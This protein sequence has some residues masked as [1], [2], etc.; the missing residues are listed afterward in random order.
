MANSKPR[1]RKDSPS[2]TPSAAPPDPDNN[3]GRGAP[4]DRDER[5]RQKSHEASRRERS[6]TQQSESHAHGAASDLDREDAD[7]QRAGAARERP[8]RRA[9]KPVRRV[10][11]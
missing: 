1:N 4:S 11:E 3:L 2:E 8:G 10:R 9:K 5:I 7:I 6:P